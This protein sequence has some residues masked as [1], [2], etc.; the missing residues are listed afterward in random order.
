MSS[1]LYDVDL[2]ELGAYLNDNITGF[3]KLNSMDKFSDGQSNPTYKLQTADK[4]YVL[5]AKPPGKLLG[6]AHQVDREYRVMNALAASDVPVPKMHHLS[7]DDNPLGAMFFVMEFID[8]RILWDPALPDSSNTERTNIFNQMNNTL[9]TLHSVDIK[10]AGLTDYGKPGNYFVRQTGRW[11]KQYHAS[12]LVAN[13]QIDRIIDWLNDHMVEDDGQTSLVHGDFR[14]DNMVFAPDQPQ[15]LAVL[16]WELSTLGH[17]LADLSY[18][19]MQWRLPASAALGG[20]GGLDRAALGIPSEQDYIGQYLDKRGL[21]P[22]NNWDFY[23]IFSIFRLIAIVQGVIKRGQDGNASDPK[24][25][26][27]MQK[28]SS[29]LTEMAIGLIK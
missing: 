29:H 11:I 17:G 12:E 2:V 14:I 26:S 18:Q 27:R 15:L 13:P 1:N 7:T 22:I 19:C 6:S 8:G 16:D 3:G 5:R 21:P 4:A 24:S 25:T 28:V 9:A 10:A 20:L 23:L